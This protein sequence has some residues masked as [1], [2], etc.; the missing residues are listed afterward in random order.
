MDELYKKVFEK[1]SDNMSNDANVDVL[2]LYCPG[3]RELFTF[4]KISNIEVSHVFCSVHLSL[5][6]NTFR[7]MW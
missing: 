7:P 5:F 4:S 3:T 1:L 2:R 6:D